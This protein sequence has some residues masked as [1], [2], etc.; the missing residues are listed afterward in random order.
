MTETNI[1]LS[2]EDRMLQAYE[3]P[4]A[5]LKVF[6]LIENIYSLGLKMTIIIFSDQHII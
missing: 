3:H 1:V 5:K 2:W 4:E 6:L